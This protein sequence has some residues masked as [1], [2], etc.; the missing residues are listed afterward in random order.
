VLAKVLDFYQEY[1]RKWGV[2]DFVDQE[3]LTLDLVLVDE[4]QDTSPMQLAIFLKLASLAKKSIWVG[5]QKQV[6]YG[7]RDADPALMD[8]AITGILKG[9]EPETLPFSWRNLNSC[10]LPLIFL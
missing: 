2:V 10:A 5:D 8:A 1:K 9:D 6:I 4:F 3:V 7:F